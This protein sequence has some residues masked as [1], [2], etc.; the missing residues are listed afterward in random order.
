[1]IGFEKSGNQTVDAADSLHILA[2][3]LR[4][5][6][7]SSALVAVRSDVVISGGMACGEACPATH[8]SMNP[9]AFRFADMLRSAK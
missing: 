3:E 5:K 2:T 9:Q 1:M 4:T 6:W 7:A 8:P